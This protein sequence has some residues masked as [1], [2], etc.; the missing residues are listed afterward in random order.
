MQFWVDQF[1]DPGTNQFWPFV[2]SNFLKGKLPVDPSPNKTHFRC[3]DE[4]QQLQGNADDPW[5]MNF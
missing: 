4:F 2:A 3:R 5:L 1:S